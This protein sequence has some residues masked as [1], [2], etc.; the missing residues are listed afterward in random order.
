LPEPVSG[1]HVLPD[2]WNTPH[3]ELVRIDAPGDLPAPSRAAIDVALLDMNHGYSN[4]G[5]DA[6]VAFVR[7]LAN[8]LGEELG[9]SGRRVRLLSYAV[10]DKM[11]VPDHAGG[12]HRLY[13]GTGGPGHL[14]PRRN[15]ADRGTAEVLED[16][17]WEAPLWRLFDEIL[18]DESAALYGVCHTFGLL[19]RWSGVAEPVLR[20]AE[21]G[22]PM[23]GVGSAAL[24]E[25]GRSHPWFGAQL[26]ELSA[27]AL[28]VLDSRYYD[29]IP[30]GRPLKRGVSAIAFESAGGERGEALTMLE[31]ARGE[32][33]DR[34][35]MFAV[36]SHPEIGSPERVQGLLER[37][38]AR[39]AITP[40]VFQQRS[41]LLPVLRDD[42]REE[43]L[44]VARAVFSDLIEHRLE[45]LVRAA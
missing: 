30:T 10:R 25:E 1:A 11:M 16:P 20:G 27:S 22:G 3:F 7:D 26:A 45:G 39:G 37:L 5:H 13:L 38:L 31:L 18:A 4:V 32:N 35:R 28:P 15:N 23:S 43:R 14:D 29:L 21:K 19:C 40:E 6:M 33:E 2:D 44:R 9:A 42:R 34:P 8:G 36:N 12:R 24:T 17:S 41:A